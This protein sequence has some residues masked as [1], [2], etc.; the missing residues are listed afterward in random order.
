MKFPITHFGFYFSLLWALCGN[1]E[2]NCGLIVRAQLF[3][4]CF[5][6]NLE[7][8]QMMS[9][10]NVMDNTYLINFFFFLKINGTI[11][12]SDFFYNYD[13][14]QT[15]EQLN[16]MTSWPKIFVFYLIALCSFFVPIWFN[17]KIKDNFIKFKI[18]KTTNFQRLM[19][20]LLGMTSYYYHFIWMEIQLAVTS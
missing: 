19:Y 14:M 10:L 16:Q 17:R 18:H 13:E 15:N 1:I 4:K 3:F 2:E 20:C 7:M 6:D 11:A 5:H 8:R 12:Y 9:G